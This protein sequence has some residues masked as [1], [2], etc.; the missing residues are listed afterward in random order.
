MSSSRKEIVYFVALCLT[1]LP[2]ARAAPMAEWSRV[3]AM[4][5]VYFV[6]LVLYYCHWLGQ[7]KWPSGPGFAQLR[8]CTLLHLSYII[9]TGCGSP[10]GRQV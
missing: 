10:H 6:A 5:I 3:C 8:L 7:R 4:E 1:L 2:L 9:A